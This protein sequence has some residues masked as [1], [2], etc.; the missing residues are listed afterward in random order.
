MD[1]TLVMGWNKLESSNGMEQTFFFNDPQ[2]HSQIGP[3]YW[4]AMDWTLV[5]GWNKLESSNG[6]EQTFFF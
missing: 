5:M 1:W 2:P 6:M 4:I 3:Y